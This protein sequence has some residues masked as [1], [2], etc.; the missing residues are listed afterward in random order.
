MFLGCDAINLQRNLL[1]SHLGRCE[2]PN[3]HTAVLYGETPSPFFLLSS[4]VP[5]TYLFYPDHRGSTFLQNTVKFPPNYVTSYNRHQQC[6]F[7][8]NCTYHNCFIYVMLQTYSTLLILPTCLYTEEDHVQHLKILRVH[9]ERMK[10]NVYHTAVNFCWSHHHQAS[11]IS[12]GNRW[13]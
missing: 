9:T 11:L 1:S 6:N 5:V 4:A 10:T 13:R 3:S 7:S 2:K 8:T 12:F